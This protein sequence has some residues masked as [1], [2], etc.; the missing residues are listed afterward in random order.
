MMRDDSPGA[1]TDWQL[2][3]YRL[4]ELPE[5]EQE[6]VRR[7]LE[8]DE[9]ARARLAAL[10]ASDAELLA[11]HTPRAMAGAIRARLVAAEAESEDQRARA[12]KARAAR[13]AAVWARPALATVCGAALVALV[14]L[15]ARPLLFQT[16]TPS[17]DDSSRTVAQA[18]GVDTN[19]GPE[20]RA[21]DSA[22]RRVREPR[23][24]DEGTET[25]SVENR[26]KGL[27]PQLVLFLKTSSGPEPLTSGA[28]AHAG[29]VV[30]IVYQA[31]GRHYGVIVSADGR[32]VVTLHLPQTGV[33]A[34]ALDRGGPVA[35]QSAYAL[36]DSPRWE[37][38]YFVTADAPFDTASVIAAARRAAVPGSDGAGAPRLDLGPG[39]EQSVFVLKKES[40][41]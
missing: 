1:M 27:G 21:L 16:P 35:L 13:G 39:L 29:D 8:T 38:F 24:P 12:E 17:T 33:A 5:A 11:R 3:R 30:Q 31:A 9:D 15:T 4:N 19:R 23:L 18:A 7:R 22:E 40:P 36:D 6:Q 10:E 41:S 20:P 32:G 37:R 14:A 25:G 28:A 34:A 2:E 26:L